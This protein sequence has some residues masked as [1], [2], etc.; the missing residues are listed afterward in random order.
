MKSSAAM[1]GCRILRRHWRHSDAQGQWNIAS[2][3]AATAKMPMMAKA[4]GPR[5]MAVA[6]G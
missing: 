4:V 3:P 6:C 2:Q 1:A 5:M